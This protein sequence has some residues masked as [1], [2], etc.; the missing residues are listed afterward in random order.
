MSGYGPYHVEVAGRVAADVVALTSITVDLDRAG[1][2]FELALTEE[3]PDLIDACWLAGLVTYSRSFVSEKR[4]G[5]VVRVAI[6]E[7]L[8]ETHRELVGHRNRLVALAGKEAVEQMAT[9][10]LTLPPSKAP[11]ALELHVVQTNLEGERAPRL[12]AY[13]EHCRAMRVVFDREAQAALER[14]RDVAESR[15]L[16]ELYEYGEGRGQLTVDD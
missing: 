1:R 8:L 16:D 4:T 7:G 15:P 9:V 6:P 11:M 14:V 2:F 10:V 3:L 12:A 5:I 13:V